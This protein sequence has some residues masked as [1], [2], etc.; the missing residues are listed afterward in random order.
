[1]NVP[2]SEFPGVADAG[3]EW[4]RAVSKLV[5][6][7]MEEREGGL[8]RCAP[9]IEG[10]RGGVDGRRIEAVRRGSGVEGRMIEVEGRGLEVAAAVHA[11][12]WEQ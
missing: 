2:L 1:M 8:E 10:R 9:G 5:L 4:V 12:H 7:D 6:I 11:S 3:D